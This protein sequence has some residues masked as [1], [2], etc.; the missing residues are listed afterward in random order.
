MNE[1]PLEA[2]EFK[3]TGVKDWENYTNVD[4]N[5]NTQTSGNN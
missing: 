1:G 3:V 2:I 5:I 4:A